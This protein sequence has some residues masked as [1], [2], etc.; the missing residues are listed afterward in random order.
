M[1]KL[2][3]HE[4]SV[5]RHV[6]HFR[7]VC[8]GEITSQADALMAETMAY[9]AKKKLLMVEMFD[10]GPTYTISLAGLQIVETFD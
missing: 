6:H 7:K 2:L 1:R 8:L 10:D 9:L 5:L 3:P 4:L